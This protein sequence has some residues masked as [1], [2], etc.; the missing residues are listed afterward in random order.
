MD[1]INEIYDMINSIYFQMFQLELNDELDDEQFDI[2][3]DFLK[4]KISEE[5][6]AVKEYIDDDKELYDKLKKLSVK[7]K[8][9][10]IVR[11]SSYVNLHELFC[12]DISDKDKIRARIFNACRDS[13]LLVF[14]S[15]L[16]EAIDSSAV[17][18]ENLLNCKYLGAFA[19]HALERL[20]LENNFYVKKDVD[21]YVD[22]MLDLLTIDKKESASVV[23]AT[24]V[25]ILFAEVER[26]LQVSDSDYEN[27]DG[28]SIS[29]CSQ[30]MIRACL[31]LMDDLDYYAFNSLLYDNL[32]RLI[33]KN[34]GESMELLNNLLNNRE[35]NKKRVR[36]VSFKDKGKN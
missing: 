22:C 16:Q 19:N 25:S 17:Y 21:V 29:I 6:D 31:S 24:Y 2:L 5:E 32:Y 20:L 7:E 1:K 27:I 36:R 34:N 26:L 13:I 11:L 9:G 15:F 30:C 3:V 18:K 12:D 33:N 14:L 4:E 10:N 8:N 23:Q 35:E 28:R